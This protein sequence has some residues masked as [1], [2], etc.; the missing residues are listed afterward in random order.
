MASARGQVARY[1]RGRVRAQIKSIAL[2]VHVALYMGMSSCYRLIRARERVVREKS[3][4]HKFGG[5]R[6]Q[7]LERFG[8]EGPKARQLAVVGVTDPKS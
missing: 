5:R 7:L 2:C 1:K 6:G 3:A 4:R 8:L